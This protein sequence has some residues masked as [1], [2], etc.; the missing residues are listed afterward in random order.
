MGVTFAVEQVVSTFLDSRGQRQDVTIQLR[1][2]PLTGRTGRVA[3]F[4]GFAVHPE[5]FADLA[6]ASR[7]VCPFCPERVTAMTGRW[8]EDLVP[9]GRLSRGEA[10]LFPNVSPYDAY[11]AVVA[12]TAR[13]DVAIDQLTAAQLADGLRLSAEFAQRVRAARPPGPAHTVVGMNLLPPAGSSLVHPHL[14]AL[15]TDHPGDREEQ[16]LAASRAWRAEHGRPYLADLIDAERDGERFVA[17]GSHTSWLTAFVSRSLMSDALGIVHGT[18]HL[19]DLDDAALDE[20]TRGLTQVLGHLASLGVRSCNLS[21]TGDAQGHDDRWLCV[22]VSPRAYLTTYAHVNDTGV[23]PHLFDE[24]VMMRPPE[25]FAAELRE[26][27]T[28]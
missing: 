17:A 20:L 12:L 27:V 22:R 2:D 8:P 10:W 4:L 11:S 24:V 6:E 28:L 19:E 5:D 23:L 26:V 18:S 9:G 25:Q 3:H 21:V 14:H 1:R 15:V 7:A 13:H 16:E